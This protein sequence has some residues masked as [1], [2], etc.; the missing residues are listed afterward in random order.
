[1]EARLLQGAERKMGKKREKKRRICNVLRA[2]EAAEE[3]VKMRDR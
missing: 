2:T 1:M 3:V